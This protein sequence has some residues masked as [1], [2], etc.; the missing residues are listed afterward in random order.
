MKW[1]DINK[2]LIAVVSFGAMLKRLLLLFYFPNWKCGSQFAFTCIHNI[3]SVG[4]N[5]SKFT[6]CISYHMLHQFPRDAVAKYQKIGFLKERKFILSQ[7]W[8]P[9]V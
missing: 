9:D 8:K 2:E 4:D 6:C 5:F 3:H 7:F 1:F